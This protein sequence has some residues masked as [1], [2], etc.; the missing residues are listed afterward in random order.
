[1]KIETNDLNLVTEVH[2]LLCQSGLVKESENNFLSVPV[3]HAVKES[4]F[5]VQM[6][7]LNTFWRIQLSKFASESQHARYCLVDEADAKQ[8]LKLLEESG[9]LASAILKDDK[10]KQIDA[11]GDIF[12][13]LTIMEAQMGIGFWWNLPFIIMS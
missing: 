3:I 13:V 11:I 8:W 10:E 9:E 7:T 5:I 2:N 12:V 6:A 1:M 4:N